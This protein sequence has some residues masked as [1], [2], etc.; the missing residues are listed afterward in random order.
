LLRTGGRWS[1]AASMWSQR[2]DV[3]ALLRT[4][5]TMIRALLLARR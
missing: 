2:V 3:Q 1:Q 5:A 4:A